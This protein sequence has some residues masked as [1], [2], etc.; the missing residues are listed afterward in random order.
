MKPP[1]RLLVF[2]LIFQF[3][4]SFIDCPDLLGQY[5]FDTWTT[6]DGLPQNGVREIA[7]TPDG[8]LWFTTFDGLVRFDGVKFTTFNK[9]NTKEIINNRF[10]NLHT[11]K[12]GTLYASTMDDGVLTVYQN[13]TFS[14]YSSEK[15]PGAYIRMMKPDKNGETRFLIIDQKRKSES[16]YYLRDNKFVLSEKINKTNVKIIYRGKSGALWTITKSQIT[17]FRNGKST[18]YHH[19]FKKLRQPREF[20][21][22]SKGALWISG[23]NLTRLKDGKINN[24]GERESFP[25]NSDFHSFWEDDDGSVWF[26]NGG[27]SGSGIGLIRFKDGNFEKYG[28]NEGLSDTNIFDVFKDRE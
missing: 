27:R 15:I 7:Q 20:F 17:E 4:V 25:T 23:L 24:F 1:K 10:T 21:E 22:D 9:S 26:A 14:S 8:Y 19:H 11:D 13:G 28:K 16:W 2:V 12:N 6:D 5:S 3:Y 18:L